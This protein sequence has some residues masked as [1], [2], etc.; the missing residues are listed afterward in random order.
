[1]NS[2]SSSQ[3]GSVESYH[4]S[5]HSRVCFDRRSKLSA[6]WSATAAASAKRVAYQRPTG[7]AKPGSRRLG[8]RHVTTKVAV[9]S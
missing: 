3:Y 6:T 8:K 1:M 9:A 4:T 5:R 2:R 7:L